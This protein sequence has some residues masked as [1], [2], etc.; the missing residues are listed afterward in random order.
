MRFLEN[1]TAVTKKEIRQFLLNTPARTSTSTAQT[2]PSPPLQF[3]TNPAA[4]IQVL[5]ECWNVHHRRNTS[6]PLHREPVEEELDTQDICRFSSIQRGQRD[7]NAKGD[8]LDAPR[9][10]KARLNAPLPPIP[11]FPTPTTEQQNLMTLAAKAARSRRH[12]AP[13][14]TLPAIGK[15]PFKLPRAEH[16]HANPRRRAFEYLARS[17]YATFAMPIPSPR[18]SSLQ[19]HFETLAEIRWSWESALSSA[20]SGS[21][22]EMVLRAVGHGGRDEAELGRD[23]SLWQDFEA[24]TRS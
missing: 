3:S 15:S 19:P 20:G 18:R 10:T 5:K 17:H 8:I 14:R 16:I 11:S 23:E 6:P 9:I 4:L 1:N 21:F 2:S 22:S 13:A 7:R 24:R 12:I